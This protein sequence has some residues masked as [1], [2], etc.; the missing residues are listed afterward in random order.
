[1]AKSP[2]KKPTKKSVK[3]PAKSTTKLPAKAKEKS[4][5][6][7]PALKPNAKPAPKSASKPLSKIDF[8]ISSKPDPRNLEPISLDEMNDDIFSTLSKIFGGKN[9]SDE[10]LNA[11]LD[12]KMATGELPSSMDLDPLDEAQSII[13]EAWNTQGKEKVKLAYKALELSDKCADAYVILAQEEAK[14]LPAKLDFYRKGVEAG[15]RSLDEDF[16]TETIGNFWM[17]METRPYMR[18]RFG[19]ADCLLKM[20]LTKEALGHFRELLVLNPSDNQGVRYTLMHLLLSLKL[21]KELGQLLAGYP[22]DGA[23][24]LLYTS[25]LL[26]FRQN[27]KKGKA[28]LLLKEAMEM[29]PHIPAFLL[30]KKKITRS[31]QTDFENGKIDSLEMGSEEEAA[32]YYFNAYSSWKETE[33]ALTW[34][35]N[36]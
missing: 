11:F 3:S 31:Q 2:I 22:D 15:K 9:L 35:A 36:S 29:N 4:S 6:K 7:K 27:D 18:A 30:G 12:S 10:D 20:G 21:D 14:T 5:P 33:G 1:M 23:A 13:Y 32:F 8:S 25:A 28:S 19:L 16:F 24:E 26:Q 34:L 17:A